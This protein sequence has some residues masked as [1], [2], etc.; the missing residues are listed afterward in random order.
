MA[1]GAFTVERYCQ[2]PPNRSRSS[3]KGVMLHAMLAGIPYVRF[4]VQGAGMN[5]RCH[6]MKTDF[7]SRR[8]TAVS[9]RFSG[10]YGHHYASGCDVG[11]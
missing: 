1:T 11:R 7:V 10:N 4:G 9:P 2:G 6:L 8:F 5:R 3:K